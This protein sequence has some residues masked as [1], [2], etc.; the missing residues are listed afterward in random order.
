MFYLSR[1]NVPMGGS[2]QVHTSLDDRKRFSYVN[3]RKASYRGSKTLNIKNILSI[4]I[5]YVYQC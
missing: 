1:V 5:K 4:L 3:V 2:Q